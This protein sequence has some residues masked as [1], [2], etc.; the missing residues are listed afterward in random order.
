MKIVSWS[1]LWL[2]LLLGGCKKEVTPTPNVDASFN[3]QFLLA[4]ERSAALPNQNSPELTVTVDDIVDTRCPRNMTCAFPGDVRA[5]VGV[6]NQAGER[7]TATLCIGCDPSTK[8]SDSA[9]VQT[10]S[11][12][13]VLLL[14]DVTPL[15]TSLN[16]PKK[17]KQV[18]LTVKR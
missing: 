12:R 16:P 9:V 14:S 13:Y 5:V 11:R 1:A 8:L 3:Q 2:A 17:D 15:P 4:F 7:Q 18:Q 6:K 10:N